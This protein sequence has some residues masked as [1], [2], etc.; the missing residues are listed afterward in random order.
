MQV[1]VHYAVS[2]LKSDPLWSIFKLL[3]ITLHVNFS[4]IILVWS[5]CYL[6]MSMVSREGKAPTSFD[7]GVV[8]NHFYQN[9]SAFSKQ[10]QTAAQSLKVGRCLSYRFT[11]NSSEISRPMLARLSD[12]PDP[13]LISS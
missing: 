4:I 10:P 11:A 7:L 2:I 13:V 8:T 3:Q 6:A 9:E 1:D 5:H 12:S